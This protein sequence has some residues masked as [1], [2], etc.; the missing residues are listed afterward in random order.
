MKRSKLLITMVMISFGISGCN[1]DKSIILKDANE[2]VQN[3]KDAEK[4]IFKDSKKI[5]EFYREIYEHALNE[6]NQLNLDTV[7]SIVKLLGEAGY[8]AVD[9]E[10]QVDMV[11]PNKVKQ[12]AE[13]V[14]NKEEA[15]ITI[16]CVLYNGGFVRY[17]LNTK[18][19]KVEVIRTSITWKDKMPEVNYREEYF[20]HTW[21]YSEEGYLFF[22]QYHMPGFDGPSGHTAI[23]VK[24]LDERSRELN[25]KYLIPIGYNLNNMFTTDWSEGDYKQL[26]FY[27]LYERMYQLKY[28]KPVSDKS[29]HEGKSYEIPKTEF[30][31][32]FQSY[33][34]I[35]SQILQQK[36]VYHAG[37]KTYQYRPRGMFDFAPTPNIPYPEVV[38]YNEEQDGTIMLTVNA[39]WPEENLAKAFSHVVVIR[40]LTDGRFQYVSNHVIH[41]KENMEPTWYRDRLTDEE[42]ANYYGAAE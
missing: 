19:G 30:Q 6:E 41:S 14:E 8:A 28:G 33:F 39:V 36:T 4:E 22:E 38:S 25:R 12:F 21:V 37:S 16:I 26:N 10:N 5:A 15:E 29:E 17:D 24:A 1:I 2:T 23:R 7:K 13:K 18:E 27:D 11:N 9:N 35:N 3:I 42:W 31:D 40:P 20:A 32:V 34:K